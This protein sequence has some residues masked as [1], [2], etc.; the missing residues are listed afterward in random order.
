ML[1]LSYLLA[2]CAAAATPE[3]RALAYLAREVPRWSAE[4]HCYSCHRLCH[5]FA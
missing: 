3:E 2:V 4:N 5:A 1:P